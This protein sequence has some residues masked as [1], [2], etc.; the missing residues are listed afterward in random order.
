[1]LKFVNGNFCLLE[2]LDKDVFICGDIDG[3]LS[4]FEFSFEDWWEK[5]IWFE[6]YE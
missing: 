1:M 4:K 5:I 6:F 3:K 2:W